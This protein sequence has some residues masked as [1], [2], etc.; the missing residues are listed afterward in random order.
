MRYDYSDGEHIEERWRKMDE[1]HDP[2]TC[3]VCG[4]PM[5]LIISKTHCPP[6]GVYSY[7]PNIGN[8][9]AF[10]RRRQAIKDGTKV[11]PKI[12]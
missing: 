7:E 12:G 2:V 5:T 3:K 11:I 4:K 8:P 1:R 6:S 9:E 10:E